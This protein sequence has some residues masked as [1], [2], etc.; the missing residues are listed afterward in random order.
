MEYPGVEK[1]PSGT[2]SPERSR[3]IPTHPRKV[4]G[5]GSEHRPNS[6]RNGGRIHV[7]TVAGLASEWWPDCVGICTKTFAAP[8]YFVNLRYHNHRLFIFTSLIPKDLVKQRSTSMLIIWK[9]LYWGKRVF[10]VP[11]FPPIQRKYLRVVG[12]ISGRQV[13]HFLVV[14]P[15]LVLVI[16]VETFFLIWS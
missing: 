2:I 6:P 13:N 5:I 10:P 11:I 8:Y 3:S 14:V 15:L 1:A 7:G 16:G 9:Y 12:H 4:A